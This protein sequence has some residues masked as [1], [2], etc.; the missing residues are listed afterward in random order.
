VLNDPVLGRVCAVFNEDFNATS[1]PLTQ[2]NEMQCGKDVCFTNLNEV[3][4]GGNHCACRPGSTRQSSKNRCE[5]VQRTSLSV[6][7]VSNGDHLLRY[8]SQY[9]SP[10]N[11]PY[12]EF[13]GD[14]KKEM[15]ELFKSTVYAPKYVTSDVLVITHPKTV[16]SSWSEGLLVNF[17]VATKQSQ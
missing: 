12:I 13:A 17:S 15:A 3:C 1:A 5:E 9:N 10:K 8:S 2:A 11:T 4:V 16:N 14:F 6:R 7:I